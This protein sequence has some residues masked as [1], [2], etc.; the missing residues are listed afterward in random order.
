MLGLQV[1]QHAQLC[2]C[3]HMCTWYMYLSCGCVH[4]CIGM[5]MHLY[6]EAMSGLFLDPCLSVPITFVKFFLH[7]FI[8]AVIVCGMEGTTWG[9]ARAG[10]GLC[11][12][13]LPQPQTFV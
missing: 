7:S 13:E 1:F 2:V 10:Q 6:V 8:K 9:L 5:C 11:P 3:L 12:T 4:M